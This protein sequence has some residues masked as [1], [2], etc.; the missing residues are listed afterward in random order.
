[1]EF[2]IYREEDVPNEA[3]GGSHACYKLLHLDEQTEYLLVKNK[4]ERSYFYK[5]YRDLDFLL[6]GISG[7]SSSDNEILMSLKDLNCVS[8]CLKL[9]KP[10]SPESVNFI[11]FQ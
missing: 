1:V 5:K 8:L 4:G 10:V 2:Q 6:F 11:Q 9:D 7:R 3:A